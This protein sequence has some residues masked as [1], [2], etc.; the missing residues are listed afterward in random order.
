MLNSWALLSVPEFE[1]SNPGSGIVIY[2]N[3]ELVLRVG[4]YLIRP[5]L[6]KYRSQ[7]PKQTYNLAL[8]HPMDEIILPINGLPKKNRKPLPCFGR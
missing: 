5:R 7:M 1:G 8:Y 3:L 2:C 6:V 4:P